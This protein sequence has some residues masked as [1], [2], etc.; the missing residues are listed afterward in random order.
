M[1][2]DTLPTTETVPRQTQYAPRFDSY[3]EF[4]TRRDTSPIDRVRRF[5]L[6]HSHFGHGNGNGHGHGSSERRC[7]GREGTA[8]RTIGPA[9][10]ETRAT[11]QRRVQPGP[12][13]YS[14]K[15]GLTP[16]A[17]RGPN[18]RTGTGSLVI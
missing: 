6:F 7:A 17:G 13:R 3:G 10:T 5:I 18:G 1:A 11:I 8:R 16:Q 15:L 9:M 14:K 12:E 4:T 2:L